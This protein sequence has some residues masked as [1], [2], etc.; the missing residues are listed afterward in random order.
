MKTNSPITC[1]VAF[2]LIGGMLWLTITTNGSTMNNFLSKLTPDQMV[3]YKRI[4]KMRFQIWAKGLLLGFIVALMTAKFLPIEGENMSACAVASIAMSVNYL[5]YTLSQKN[6]NMLSYLKQE[7][8][9]S[10]LEV[11]SMMTTKYHIGMLLGLIGSFLLSKGLS[12][13]QSSQIGG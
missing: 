10:W 4:E 12:Q 7:Q 11:K 6:E 3:V 9:A 8:I 2:A 13:T 5:Y 1:A